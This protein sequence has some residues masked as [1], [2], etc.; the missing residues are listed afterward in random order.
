MQQTARV[1]S[2]QDQNS[3]VVLNLLISEKIPVVGWIGNDK[4][5]SIDDH[6]QA[7]QPVKELDCVP[8]IVEK[9]CRNPRLNAV[10]LRL[11]EGDSQAL[12]KQRN[13][14]LVPHVGLRQQL[15]AWK[16][17]RHGD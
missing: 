12:S 3:R 17:T 6:V 7:A 15:A 11:I 8:L 10:L 2:A 4:R 5:L 16:Q 14:Q 1:L 13:R 9:F